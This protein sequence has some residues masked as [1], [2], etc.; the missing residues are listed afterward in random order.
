MLDPFTASLYGY[1]L[2]NE[3]LTAGS[4]A[5]KN[6]PVQWF[7][8]CLDEAAA[9]ATEFV[10]TFFKAQQKQPSDA[11]DRQSQESEITITSLQAELKL[12]MTTA[13]LC[14]QG[15]FC[16]KKEIIRKVEVVIHTQKGHEKVLAVFRL[17]LDYPQLALTNLCMEEGIKLADFVTIIH[18]VLQQYQELTNWLFSPNQG[19]RITASEQIEL[20]AHEDD[21]EKEILAEINPIKNTNIR[22][23]LRNKVCHPS[24]TNHFL[25][26]KL[27]L[28]METMRPY[29]DHLVSKFPALEDDFWE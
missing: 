20:N 1:Y 13:R 26:H 27:G 23:F 29:L 4:D 3:K 9:D 8:S 2:Q 17:K 21:L 7:N 19:L 14:P 16:S 11:A 10:D 28:S 22:E 25:C 5:S 15:S 12:T 6:Q 18:P 24:L